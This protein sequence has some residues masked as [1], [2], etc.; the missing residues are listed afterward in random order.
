MLS[1][2]GGRGLEQEQRE[3]AGLFHS[4][5]SGKWSM[6]VW[7]GCNVCGRAAVRTVQPLAGSVAG[8]LEQQEAVEKEGEGYP[9]LGNSW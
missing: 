2:G 9:C 5:A 6:C 8:E 1:S 7:H 4:K 3:E